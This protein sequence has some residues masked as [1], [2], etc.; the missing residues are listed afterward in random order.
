MKTKVLLP[1]M[2]MDILLP[3]TEMDILL[4]DMATDMH[5]TLC[6]CTIRQATGMWETIKHGAVVYTSVVSVSTGFTS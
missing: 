5:I 2:K 3:H 6:Q 4:R 1:H